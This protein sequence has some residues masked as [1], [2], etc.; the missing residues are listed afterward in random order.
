VDGALVEPRT[1]LGTEPHGEQCEDTE[2]GGRKEDA[3]EHLEHAVETTPLRQA[4]NERLRGQGVLTA[5]AGS[6]GRR[7][8]ALRG[9]A[10]HR[11]GPALRVLLALRPRLG[12]AERRLLGLVGR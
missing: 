12:D 3:D 4:V 2:D 6:A 10:G 7:R 5:Q 8:L 9:D 1:R 11:V